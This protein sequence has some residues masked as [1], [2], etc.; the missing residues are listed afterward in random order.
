M[1]WRSAI[2]HHRQI[3]RIDTSSRSGKLEGARI[4]AEFIAG[5]INELLRE[6]GEGDSGYGSEEI[7]RDDVGTR[8]LGLG[9]RNQFDPLTMSDE[10]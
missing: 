2:L 8:R 1:G 7:Q 3:R 5:K 4:G 10:E 6:W 9:M